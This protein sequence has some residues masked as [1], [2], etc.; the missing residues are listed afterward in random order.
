MPDH[1]P[2]VHP[3]P[4]VRLTRKLDKFL[5]SI[6]RIA[7]TPLP[8]DAISRPSASTI[9]ANS[10]TRDASASGGLQV[11]RCIE[12]DRRCLAAL[13]EAGEERYRQSMSGEEG[14]AIALRACESAFKTACGEYHRVLRLKGRSSDIS[15]ER[16]FGMTSSQ[17]LEWLAKHIYVHWAELHDRDIPGKYIRMYHMQGIP[18]QTLQV[19]G[20]LH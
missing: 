6:Y 2:Q 7:C 17:H 14:Q 1:H 4:P 16:F 10:D 18:W 5:I 19:K 9:V 11:G 15:K 3:E 12:A 8:E 20:K 13:Q